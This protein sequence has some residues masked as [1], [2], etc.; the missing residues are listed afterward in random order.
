M[1]VSSSV[2]YQCLEII[3]ICVKIRNL[4][5]IK[6]LIATLQTQIGIYGCIVGCKEKYDHCLVDESFITSFGISPDWLEIY[7]TDKLDAYDPVAHRAFQTE[8]PVVWSEIYQSATASTKDF[9]SLSQDFRLVEGV[10]CANQSNRFNG[11]ATCVSA[12][13]DHTSIA[14]DRILLLQ[15]IL[16]H[17]NEAVAQPNLLMVDKFTNREIEILQWIQAGKSSWEIGVILAISERTVKFHL[18][19]IYRKLDVHSRAQA[20]ARAMRLGLIAM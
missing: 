15:R 4:K 14:T 16:P 12:I 3:D 20:V 19:N 10:S 6:D 5:G 18:S 9:I 7:K 8:T 17:L 1:K 11:F 2:N 13:F